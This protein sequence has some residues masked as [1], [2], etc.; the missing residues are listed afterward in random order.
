MDEPKWSGCHPINLCRN[1]KQIK[2]T[3]GI[4]LLQLKQITARIFPQPTKKKQ[5]FME[6]HSVDFKT[7]PTHPIYGMFTY[8]PTVGYCLWYLM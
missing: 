5:R 6:S 3:S 2:R 8:S 1:K 7:K 4:I